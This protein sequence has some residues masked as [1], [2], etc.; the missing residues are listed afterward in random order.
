[1]RSGAG[2][3]GR[4]DRA[5]RCGQQPLLPPERRPEICPMIPGGAARPTERP[6]VATSSR[7]GPRRRGWPTPGP[8]ALEDGAKRGRNLGRSTS[9][10]TQTGDGRS[11]RSTASKHP[12]AK[13]PASKHP[14]ARERAPQHLVPEYLGPQQLGPQQQAPGQ[15]ERTQR[16]LCR[17]FQEGQSAQ[18]SASASAEEPQETGPALMTRAKRNP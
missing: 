17:A 4:G 5:Y 15:Q 13:H 18:S 12:A 10:E 3:G 8:P 6:W 9:V 7:R 11:S 1:M 14:V 16:V 2:C